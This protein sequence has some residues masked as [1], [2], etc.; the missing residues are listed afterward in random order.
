MNNSDITVTD[1]QD[2]IIGPNL[3]EECGE[4]VSKGRKNDDC[5]SH[6]AIY[7]SSFIQVF[8]SFLRRENDLVENDIRLVLDEYNPSFNTYQLKPGFYT[9]KEFSEAPFNNLQAEYELINN[10]VDF[11][12]YEITTKSILVVRWCIIAIR[13]VEKPFCSTIMGFNPYWKFKHYREYIS[14]KI[15]SSSTTNK[16]IW[17]VM[18]LIDLWWAVL[19]NQ[20]F[21][22]CFR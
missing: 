12:F 3:F 8:E 9:F 6:L 14:Q 19:D 22:C 7:N 13:Y 11:D 2:D 5:M 15:V 4:Q 16:N 20:Y 18:I 17:F 21:Y 1:L 10:S